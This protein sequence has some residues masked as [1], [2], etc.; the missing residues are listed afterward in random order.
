MQ[1]YQLEQLLPLASALQV[2]DQELPI[3]DD[4]PILGANAYRLPLTFFRQLPDR[5]MD[6]VPEAIGG[7]YRYRICP[8]VS[9][10][11][12]IAGRLAG[13]DGHVRRSHLPKPC[14]EQMIRLHAPRPARRRSYR[15]R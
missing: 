6:L 7:E 4:T 8:V 11:L 12:V 10:T 13:G 9:D 14:C 3:P 2:L 1:D 15:L 5:F